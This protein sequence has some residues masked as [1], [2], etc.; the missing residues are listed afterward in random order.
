MPLKINKGKNISTS[1]RGN[2]WNEMPQTKK[3]PDIYD[4]NDFAAIAKQQGADS[5]TVKNVIDSAN[6]RIGKDKADTT[7]LFK[8]ELVRSRFAA[9]DPFRRNDADLLGNINPTLLGAMGVG[10]TG[11]AVGATQLPDE[12]KSAIANAFS[13][14]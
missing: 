8:P 14:R 2:Y 10:A 4:V 11:A 12:Y 5:A 1:A 6:L 13:G 9:F 3:Y 7:F